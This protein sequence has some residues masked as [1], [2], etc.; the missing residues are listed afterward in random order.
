MPNNPNSE[1]LLRLIT[2]WSARALTGQ[3]KEWNSRAFHVTHS[4]MA[5][6]LTRRATLFIN[7]ACGIESK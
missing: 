3:V 5:P 6:S 7:S 1:Q 2:G 4:N